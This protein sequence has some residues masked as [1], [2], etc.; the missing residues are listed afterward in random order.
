M[1][2]SD[3]TMYFSDTVHHHK[4]LGNIMIYGCD[5]ECINY[6]DIATETGHRLEDV[7]IDDFRSMLTQPILKHYAQGR[8]VLWPFQ[9]GDRFYKKGLH[10]DRIHDVNLTSRLAKDCPTSYD[11]IKDIL[12]QCVYK[13]LED[14]SV[15]VKHRGLACISNSELEYVCILDEMDRPKR[16]KDFHFGP[17]KIEANGLQCTIRFFVGNTY[18]IYLRPDSTYSPIVLGDCH[19]MLKEKLISVLEKKTLNAKGREV[20]GDFLAGKYDASLAV[21]LNEYA[22]EDA[23][24]FFKPVVRVVTT[25]CFYK[26]IFLGDIGGDVNAD[27]KDIKFFTDILDT[28]NRR[29]S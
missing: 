3:F 10:A 25:K 7:S 14:I 28:V 21:G 12:G 2:S 24:E 26:S 6:K 27:L 4:E 20:L 16:E 8:A 29:Y 22:M 23:E 18:D 15:V 13:R 19:A 17:R 1:D 9:R 5:D 11:R